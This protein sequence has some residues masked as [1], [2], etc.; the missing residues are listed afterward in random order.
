[1][2]APHKA[3]IHIQG[4]AGVVPSIRAELA[5]LVEAAPDDCSA[6]RLQ[7]F[8]GLAYRLA[9]RGMSTDLTTSTC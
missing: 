8:W 4:S 6:D 5:K 9:M 7:Q 3:R 2:T 1:M